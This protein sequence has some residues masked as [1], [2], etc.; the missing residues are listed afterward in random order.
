MLP[1]LLENVVNHTEVDKHAV[2]KEDTVEAFL[3]TIGAINGEYTVAEAPDIVA[4]PTPLPD[5]PAGG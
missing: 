3:N 5:K 2:D 1:L 4:I